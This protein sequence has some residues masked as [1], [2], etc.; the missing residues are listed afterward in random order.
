[1]SNENDIVADFFLG[2]GTTAVACKELDR[3]Y[4]GFEINKKWYD[5]AKDRLNC[6][7]ASGQIS[8]VLR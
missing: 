1:M 4:I 8:L 6:V 7:D 5:I 3:Q 2:S